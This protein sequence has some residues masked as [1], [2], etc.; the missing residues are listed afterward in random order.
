MASAL[1]ASK[2]AALNFNAFDVMESQILGISSERE[3]VG[4]CYLP[5]ILID[6]QS[7]S[8]G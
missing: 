1:V 6:A 2:N 7:I 8:A 4:D 5:Y 3:W